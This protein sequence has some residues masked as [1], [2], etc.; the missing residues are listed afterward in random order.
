[1]MRASRS[2]RRKSAKNGTDSVQTISG[3]QLFNS[4][5]AS[6]TTVPIAPSSFTRALAIADLFQFYRFTKIRVVQP[7]ISVNTTSGTTQYVIHSYAPGSEFDTPP[8]TPAQLVELPKVMYHGLGKA[9]D[10]NLV[11]SRKDLLSHAQLPWFKTIAGTEDSQFEI[12]GNLYNLNNVGSAVSYY[13]EYDVEFQSPNLA[14][15]S[16]FFRTPKSSEGQSNPE[17]PDIVT[18]FGAKYVLLDEKKMLGS[19]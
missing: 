7:P 18:L 5:N 14:A 16:P 3:R 13:I 6:A 8:T 17:S 4:T 9:V 1:M 12:Q 10:S 11:L 2:S 15:Q 19:K